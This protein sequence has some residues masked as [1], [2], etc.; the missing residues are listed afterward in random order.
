MFSA[1]RRIAAHRLGHVQA[2][3]VHHPHRVQVRR[4]RRVVVTI[5]VIKESRQI[6]AAAVLPEAVV[7][8]IYT[9]KL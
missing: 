1:A 9:Y 6:E 2:L 5:D 8:I 4:H 7:T 3:R